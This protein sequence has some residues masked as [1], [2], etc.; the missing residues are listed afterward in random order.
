MTKP[1]II[2]GVYLFPDLVKK[3]AKGHLV[4]RITLTTTA[5]C[6]KT[7]SQQLTLQVIILQKNLTSQQAMKSY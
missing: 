4:K 7:K 3:C 1:E 2:L 5:F 6:F